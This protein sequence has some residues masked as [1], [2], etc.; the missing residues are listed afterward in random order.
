MAYEHFGTSEPIAKEITYRGTTST[1][2][3]KP[4]TAGERM[5][6]KKGQVGTVQEGK[7][8]FDLDLGDI[9]AKNHQQL[10]FSNCDENGKRIFNNQSEVGK[11]PG[12]LFDALFAAC[13]AALDESEN[14]TK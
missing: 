13:V 1:V 10:Y 4:L 14:P 2:Y 3:F 12:G 7:S 5:Q 11:L 6:L 9:D 8:S